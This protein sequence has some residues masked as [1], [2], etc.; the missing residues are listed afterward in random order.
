MPNI[1][2]SRITNLHEPNACDCYPFD[3]PAVKQLRTLEFESAVT[4]FIGENGSG[5]SL[6]IHLAELFEKRYYKQIKINE[7]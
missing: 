7:I 2:L 6:E 4:Y 1:Y 5:Q 3:I